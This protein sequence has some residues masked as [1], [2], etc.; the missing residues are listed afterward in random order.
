MSGHRKDYIVAE[1]VQAFDL[2]SKLWEFKSP[3]NFL[4]LFPSLY[5][6]VAQLVEQWIEAPCVGG[7]NPS[8]TTSMVSLNMGSS[9][10]R[11]AKPPQG[12]RMMES[13]IRFGD[14]AQLVEQVIRT[15]ANLTPYMVATAKRY[16][17]IEMPVSQ[18]RVLP[19]PQLQVFQISAKCNDLEH[20]KCFFSSVGLEHYL[21]RV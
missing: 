21:D 2:K 1:L 8:R 14:V 9:P 5:G 16:F 3:Q 12:S 17:A 6:A 18:V 10:T 4:S 7:S 13:P 15:L 11:R 20:L 19:S